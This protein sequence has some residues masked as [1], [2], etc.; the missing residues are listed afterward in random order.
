MTKAKEYTKKN[1]HDDT[2]DPTAPFYESQAF[3]SIWQGLRWKQIRTRVP[4]CFSKT[5]RS[6]YMLANL[7]YLGYAIGI[8]IIDFNPTVN[9]S[10]SSS[11]SSS[12]D[13][14]TNSSDVTGTTDIAM[15]TTTSMSVLDGPV[16]STP[17]INHLYLGKQ[18]LR[19]SPLVFLELRW[20]KVCWRYIS[21]FGFFFRFCR[22]ASRNSFSLLVGMGWSI[23]A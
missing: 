21:C 19:D 6:R 18:G 12:T 20:N 4:V 5:I 17:L 23:V 13:N 1:D 14:S 7:V 11:S 16:Y 2:N 3:D 15:T 22:C 8:L 10:S 9:G